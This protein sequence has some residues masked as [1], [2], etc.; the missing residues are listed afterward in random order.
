[1]AAAAEPVKQIGSVVTLGMGVLAILAVQPARLGLVVRGREAVLA[2]AGT[3]VA[4]ALVRAFPGL[5]GILFGL[6]APAGFAEGLAATASVFLLLLALGAVGGVS[7]RRRAVRRGLALLAL[8]GALF[9]D[10]GHLLVVYAAFV[11]LV[12]GAALGAPSVDRWHEW[13]RALAQRVEAG[14]PVVIGLRG[15]EVSRMRIER[16]P[17]DV[18]LARRGDDV[19]QV[20]VTAG[21]PPRSPPAW[22][23]RHRRAAQ[24]RAARL[25][26]ASAR[27]QV[28]L[29]AGI[30][31][32][33][34]VRGD[35]AAA[36]DDELRRLLLALPPGALAVW[37]SEGARWRG[38]PAATPTPDRPVPM[39]EIDAG[40]PAPTEDLA[41]V[42]QVV[43]EVARRSG[44]RC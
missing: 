38:F 26:E 16:G 4:A 6:P 36:L 14:E 2:G 19:V 7:R 27:A 1:M 23:A 28:D 24:P 9:G 34:V 29:A 42:V 17:V 8:T 31:R 43:R 33:I 5:P 3:F 13:V 18:R 12:R 11:L 30:D 10:S 39:S 32:E 21:S 37:P 20:D 40:Q 15:E 35:G 44:I 41:G 22:S 25:P